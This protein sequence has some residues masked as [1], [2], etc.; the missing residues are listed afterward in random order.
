MRWRCSSTAAEGRA[1]LLKERVADVDVWSAADPEVAGRRIGHRPKVVEVPRR[2]PRSQDGRPARPPHPPGAE[3]LSEIAKGKNNAAIAEALAL[4]RAGR[5]EA[6]QLDLRQARAHGGARDQPAG[7]GG[8]AV[9]GADARPGDG[10]TTSPMRGTLVR[11][12]GPAMRRWCQMA[13]AT[14]LECWSST[15]RRRSGR[16]HGGRGRDAGF[17]V[18]GRGRRPARSRCRTADELHPDLILMDINIP[19]ISGHRGHRADR[20]PPS[21]RRVVFL[22]FDIRLRRPAPRAPCDCGAVALRPQGGLRPGGAQ[23]TC[24]ATSACA[25]DAHSR[26]STCHRPG[27]TRRCHCL[28]TTSPRT[29]AADGAEPVAPC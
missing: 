6:H 2:A 16:R 15:T 11:G 23:R 21:P 7:E 26:P 20:A 4:Q 9:P 13:E 10:T 12:R 5:R 24:A 19:G 27:P 25:A 29:R 17:E 18:G 28:G 3:I 8:A 1:Y 14:D 22:L